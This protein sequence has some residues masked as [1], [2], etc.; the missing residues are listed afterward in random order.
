MDF[1][2]K[3]PISNI[4]TNDV[5]YKRQLSFYSFN[6]HVISKL[7]SYFYC[8]SENVVAKGSEEVVSMLHHFIFTQLDKTPLREI[9][10][11]SIHPR[12]LS[13][14]SNY[15]GATETSLIRTASINQTKMPGPNEFFLPDKKYIE[16]IPISLEKWDNLQQLKTFCEND[17]V[18][19][20]YGNLPHKLT[21]KVK[22]KR[23]C[24]A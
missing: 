16:P 2:K 23:K 7:D 19:E 9:Q 24:V 3:L 4:S 8:Y 13:Y 17:G 15:N 1:Q 10:I 5:Y 21:R 11:E 18:S 20:F 22:K 12:Y 14:R 6:T